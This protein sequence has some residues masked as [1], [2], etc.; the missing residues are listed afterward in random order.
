MPANTPVCVYVY[1]IYLY[2]KAPGGPL[3]I[4]ERYNRCE[5]PKLF[6]IYSI[7]QRIIY[8]I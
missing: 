7:R 8:Y 2:N 5:I 6:L 4:I 3:F 1:N